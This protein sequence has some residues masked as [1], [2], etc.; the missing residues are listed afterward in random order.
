VCR[1]ARAG[2]SVINELLEGAQDAPWVADA[3]FAL[4]ALTLAQAGRDALQQASKT[5][6]KE[7]SNAASD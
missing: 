5:A 3:A 6:A 7:A 2:A 1:H 4:A